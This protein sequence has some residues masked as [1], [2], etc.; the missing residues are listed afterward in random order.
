MWKCAWQW[1]WKWE[2]VHIWWEWKKWKRQKSLAHTS[3]VNNKLKPVLHPTQHTQRRPTHRT[4]RNA[5]INTAFIFAFR[6]LRPCVLHCLRQNG[7]HGLRAALSAV[8]KVGEAESYIFRQNSDRRLRIS[9]RGLGCS[10]AKF[11]EHL[12]TILRQFYDILHTYTPP[13]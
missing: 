12:M 7:T 8:N 6:P 10:G 11:I 13:C 9:D 2:W 3:S 1:V 4:Q 5:R